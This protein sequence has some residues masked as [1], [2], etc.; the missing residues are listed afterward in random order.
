M[1]RNTLFFILL[2]SLWLIVNSVAQAES[3][4][5]DVGSKKETPVAQAIAEK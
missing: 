3:S 1:K 2:V 4:F 5:F